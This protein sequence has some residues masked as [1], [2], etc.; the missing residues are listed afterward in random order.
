M[1]IALDLTEEALELLNSGRTDAAKITLESL[2]V[3]LS[4]S[5]SQGRWRLLQG[6]RWAGTHPVK[7]LR[8]VTAA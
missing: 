6:L 1:R 8:K 4:A 7:L 2:A 3:H 5:P